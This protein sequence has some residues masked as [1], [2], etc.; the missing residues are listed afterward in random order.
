[1]SN[2]E[3]TRLQHWLQMPQS[4]KP[5]TKAGLQTPMGVYNT[6]M[7][8]PSSTSSPMIALSCQTCA[9]HTLLVHNVLIAPQ[10]TLAKSSLLMQVCYCPLLF[11][12]G[13]TSKSRLRER[14]TMA[15]FPGSHAGLPGSRCLKQVTHTFEAR[16]SS[17]T[18]VQVWCHIPCLASSN[19][20]ACLKNGLALASTSLCICHTCLQPSMAMVASV[21]SDC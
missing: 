16:G 4:S 5:V 9:L 10:Q 19:W 2:S 6:D 13:H 17:M 21:N 12:E 14:C 11:I 7:Q 20:N 15:R 3:L 8:T 18:A 1:M